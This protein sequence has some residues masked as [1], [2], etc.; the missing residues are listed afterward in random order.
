MRSF[1]TILAGL[2]LIGQSHIAYSQSTL[3][4][5]AKRPLRPSD[6]YRL[7]AISDPQL[8]PDGK[9]VAYTISTIDSVKDKRA[10]SIWMISLD[11]SQ[12]LR[13][14]SSPEGESRPRWSPD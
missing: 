8:S 3:T 13:I 12:D 4:P 10:S 2:A 1:F 11:G 5:T 14:T 9:W 7:P 6:I